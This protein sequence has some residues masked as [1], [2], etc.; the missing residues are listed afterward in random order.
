MPKGATGAAS[1]LD[2][3]TPQDDP[4]DPRATREGRYLPRRSTTATATLPLYVFCGEHL[5]AAKLRRSNIDGQRKRARPRVESPSIPVTTHP[6]ALAKGAPSCCAPTAASPARRCMAWCEANK[7]D[8]LFPVWP[9]NS[10]AGG[11]RSTS[12]W[13]GPRTRPERTRQK[14]A[15]RFA[16]FRWATRDSW[17]RS[18]GRDRGQGRVGMPR[19]AAQA[20][21]GQPP[22][23]RHPPRS[24]RTEVHAK[25]ALASACTV[26]AATWRT[27]S[28]SASS[29]CSPTAPKRGDIESQPK[30]RLWFAFHGLR[31]CSPRPL[32]RI[33][34]A[35]Y[36][37]GK[38]NLRIAA[39]LKLLKI[40]A[41]VTVTLPA[42]SASP[43]PRPVPTQRRSPST[44]ARLCR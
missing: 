22:A 28:R 37:T 24:P 18:A 40:G 1:T 17:R 31:S 15:C 29:T 19:T 5:L 42:A 44:H 16:D 36:P 25:N 9:G 33:A 3:W 27:G 8:Y 39:P 2:P 7:V 4:L 35:A 11:S 30:L 43:W 41:Q 26:H 10:R 32:R 20:G 6:R 38:G 13:P 21:G 14:P 34:L 12:S 23:R